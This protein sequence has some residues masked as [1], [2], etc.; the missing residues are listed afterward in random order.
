V[1]AMGRKQ[2]HRLAAR[3][4][5]TISYLHQNGG[6]SSSNRMSS[7][8]RDPGLPFLANHAD[9]IWFCD[10]IQAYGHPIPLLGHQFSVPLQ[11]GLR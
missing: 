4:W 3:G 6:P 11:D 1:P 8:R 5:I 2:I 7:D 10:S 9:T